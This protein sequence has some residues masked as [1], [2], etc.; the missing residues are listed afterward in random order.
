MH[1]STLLDWLYTAVYSNSALEAEESPYVFAVRIYAIADKYDVPCLRLAA[2]QEMDHYC[3]DV[4]D[5]ISTIR[6]IDEYTNP[7]DSNL[8]DIMLRKVGDTIDDLL[9]VQEFKDLLLEKPE[10]N[11]RLLKWLSGMAKGSYAASAKRR[12]FE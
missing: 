11:F 9:E 1:L 3:L 12:R 2:A 6:A 7:G 4:E 10:F 8:W 5:Y